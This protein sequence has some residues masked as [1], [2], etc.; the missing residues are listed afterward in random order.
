MNH[1]VVRV[2]ERKFAIIVTVGFLASMVLSGLPYTI[3][4]NLFMP[5]SHAHAAGLNPIQ[6]ENSKA[7]TPGWD[8][9]ASDLAPD[10]ISGFGS[11]ISVN[12]GDALDLYVTTTAPS[13]KIDVFRTGYYGGVGARLITSLGSFPGLHQAIP[14]PNSVT[15]MIS[16]T[17]WTKTTT[18]TI[19][20]TWVTGVYLAKLTSSTNNAS[21]IY[22]VV[23]N[24]GGNEDI[25]FQTSVT[26][27]QAY[28]TWGGTSLYNNNLT[29]KAAYPYPHATKVSFDRPFNPGDGNGAG[30]YF[31][32]EYHFVYWM[33]QQGYNVAYSTDVDTDTRP[34][35]LLAHKA[36]LSVGHDEYWT[37]GM[38][39]AVQSAINAGVNVAFFAA[40]TAYWQIRLEPN[41]AGV[42]SRIE[43]GY[44]D[45][46]TYASAPGPDPMWN[47]NNS[48]VTTLWRDPVVNMPENGLLGVMYEQQEDNDYAYVVANASNWI[49]AGTGFVDGS[50]VPGIVGYEYDKV[51]NNG[52][53]PANETV[54]SNSP[55]NGGG[56]TS[57]AN[58]TLYTAPSGARVFAAGTI[59]WSW[60]LASVEGNTYT[61]AGIQKTTANILNNF[62][63][64]TSAPTSS[65][66]LSADN[67]SFGNQGVNKSGVAQ[68]VKVTN[69]GAVALTIS[70]IAVTGTN[71]SDFAQTNTCPASLAVN[72]SCTINATFQPT[73]SGGRS[74]NIT[75]TDSAAM[76]PQ[77]IVM[78]GV[79]I[80]SGA[81]V[82][83]SVSNINFG[84]QTLNTSSAAQTVKVTNTGTSTLTFSYIQMQGLNTNDFN[85]TNNCPTSLATGASC[86]VT[87]A[88]KP[89]AVSTRSGSL[90][91]IDNAADSAEQVVL[92]GTG[93]AV[94]PGVSLNPLN[95]DF[96]SQNN[97]TTSAAKTTTLTNTS[98]NA[99]AISSI[100]ITGTDASDFAQ[101]NT[102]PSSLA[103]NASCTI[104]VTFSPPQSTSSDARSASLIVTD[105][106]NASPQSVTLNGTGVVVS[107]GAQLS[108]N[109]LSFGNQNSGTTSNAQTITLTNNGKATL[110]ISSIAMTGTNGS[111][112]T[113]T[114]TCPISPNTLAINASCTISVKFAP[115][116]SGARNAM[117]TLTDNI[118]GE[119]EA[120]QNVLLSGTGVNA[121]TTVYFNDD[122]ES[123]DFSQWTN[124]AS[125]TGSATV[126]KTVVNN[127]T[128]AAQLTN[129]AGQSV[130]VSSTFNGTPAM[131]YTRF[132]YR[133]A[134]LSG[135]TLI[136]QGQD[137]SGHNQWIMYYDSGRQG[138]DIYFWNGAGAR[139][140]VYS[141]T[142]VLSA[143]TWY[144]IEVETNQAT[145]GHGEVWLNGNSIGSFNGDLT[146]MLTYGKLTLNNDVTGTVYFDDVAVANN[147]TIPTTTSV[148]KLTPKTASFSSQVVGT[149][150]GAKAVTV[151]NTGADALT[152]SSIALAGSNA[153]DFAQTNNCP[154]S[155]A[156][157]T[158]CTINVT[159]TPTATGARTAAVTLMDSSTDSPQMLSISGTGTP[160]APVAMFSPTSLSYGNHNTGTTSTAQMVTLTNGGT[161]V[162]NIGSIAVT[163]TNA[164]NFAQTNTC[165]STLAV[166]ASCSI[167][168][169]FTPTSS[170]AKSANIAIT[171]DA[172]G[173][174][175]TVALSGTGVGNGGAS[176]VY[177]SDGFESGNFSKWTNGTSGT[178][179]ATVQTSVINKGNDAAQLTNANGQSMQASTAFSGA[180]AQTYTR[181]FYRFAS[182]SGTT[183][184]AQGLDTTGHN[185]W[186]MYYD[187]GRKGLDI[188]FWNAAN[189]RYDVYS[190]TNVLSANTWYAIE[191][192]TNQATSGHGEVWLNGNS[193][194][195][196]D[197]DLTQAQSYGKLVLNNDVTGSA[198]FDDVVVSSGYNGPVA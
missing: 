96:G 17:N 86:T 131:T 143:N 108:T 190:N 37:M 34:A 150:S 32:F 26:T 132:F 54:L 111:D 98:A 95:I 195:S 20:S 183:L 102:C 78:T 27:Y 101:T 8:D 12:H 7:G 35:E 174:P 166:G 115:T 189:T 30:H 149:T 154:A 89:T 110:A 160:A 194:G 44:K 112:F 171:D 123:G 16:C 62:I 184:I 60:G 191:V 121:N 164:N 173:S 73:A 135:T 177:F 178:G 137:S 63:S 182:L 36:F 77:V 114:N 13:F 109:Q 130:Q 46:A 70:K 50:K 105:N 38:R 97:G 153:S 152:I 141:N 198:Y 43:V 93:I 10:T 136:A 2:I 147:Y 176:A 6:V 48:L 185:Q 193:I 148:V 127:G 133:F 129:T 181:F 100:A 29:N 169:T 56:I 167:S 197:G 139:Y 146:Q 163:G 124:G 157:N 120:S 156:V 188:Y 175:Q 51:W 125:G 3:T 58:S 126:Q 23:R 84:N 87:V 172:A 134:S 116:A 75:L 94:N 180:P 74:A 91:F 69:T 122:F 140:D 128:N 106:G 144:A 103:S 99:L 39:N 71:G 145:S 53:S 61:N 142:N 88:F 162:L 57:F 76:S 52:F 161:A 119:G 42:A 1:R 192:E 68:T 67:M 25:L 49:Y 33:E 155:L 64:A 138:L 168:I 165:A 186:I 187:S 107:S 21:F 179:S 65:V 83:L 196:F 31:F 82:N 22:F 81:A 151:A 5:A 92:S 159:F 14:A 59:Q 9:F 47:T 80:A 66:T 15:G 72:A 55:V 45:F 170:G 18:L 117:L 79:G 24:D 19:P 40:N 4:R 28:N 85:Q 41:T 11:K 113:Q 118:D 90:T 158:T 104:S